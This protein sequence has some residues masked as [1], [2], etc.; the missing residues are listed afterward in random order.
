MQRRVR[1]LLPGHPRDTRRR[2][3]RRL[4]CAS[5]YRLAG[6]GEG[7]W[8]D[9]RTPFLNPTVRPQS[10]AKPLVIYTGFFCF[11]ESSTLFPYLLSNPGTEG[12]GLLSASGQDRARKSKPA[13][14]G[15]LR[16]RRAA[17]QSQCT[18]A[19][20]RKNQ[21]SVW[22][23]VP[24]RTPRSSQGLPKNSGQ[25]GDNLWRGIHPYTVPVE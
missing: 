3:C 23:V 15:R 13:T 8:F 11:F 16:T 4:A 14:L 2:E 25:S 18:Q 6:G 9:W 17:R 22:P 5:S 21:T 20:V 1:Y 10:N 12:K 7:S 19:A 24:E